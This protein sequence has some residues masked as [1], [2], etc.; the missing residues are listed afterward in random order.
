MPPQSLEMLAES[1]KQNKTDSLW[2]KHTFFI[3]FWKWND[4]SVGR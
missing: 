2:V 4:F 3:V 1:K